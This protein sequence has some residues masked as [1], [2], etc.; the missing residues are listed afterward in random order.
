MIDNLSLPELVAQMFV[1][2]ASGYLFDHQIRYRAWEPTADKL[3]YYLENLGVGGV[4]LVGGSAA[5]LAVRS[6]QLQS[7]AKFPLLLAADIEE[8]VGQR[9]AGATWFGPPMAIAEIARHDAGKA[10]RYAE[11]MGAVTAIEA[12][13]IGLNWILAPVV[14]VNN[15]PDNPVINVRAFGETS[16]I[17]GKLASA[18]IRGALEHP[19]LTTAKHF[20]GHGDTAVDSHL[21]LPVLP[22]SPDRLAE[23]ELPP[24]VGAIAAGVDA[25]MS[26]HLL[27]P[28][29]D[30]QFPATLS[31]KILIGKLREEL[32]F[33][34]L[35]VT[36]ALV[37]GAIANKYGANEAAVLA[38]EAGA[39]VLL[40]PLDPEGAI[41][42]V[43][44]AVTQGR[45][46]IAQIKESV[47]R[48]WKAKIKVGLS[49]DQ[50]ATNPK[51][52]PPQP[53]LSKGGSSSDLILLATAEARATAAD[54]LRDSLKFGGA[55]PLVAKKPSE[56]QILRNLIVVDDVLG[57][58]FLGK[59]T[60]AIA[61]PEQF[62]YELQLIDDRTGDLSHNSSAEHFSPTL[63]QIFIRGNC[64]RGSA[65]LTQAAQDWFKNLLKTGELQAVVVYGSPYVLEQFLP[66]LPPTI[67][68]IFCFGQMPA[69]QSLTL[70]LL[71]G[72]NKT[73]NA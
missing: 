19:I 13:A 43:C 52:D 20:P 73:G 3:R 45:L 12:R 36:D 10:D 49:I 5:E 68:Y 40:M 63:L 14:D 48:I 17:V 16:E 38:A 71:F 30:D 8:G 55:L 32:G 59:H 46:D 29:W 9:F 67:P 41:L 57:C 4:I 60:P 65:G 23:I 25:V 56:K 61:I 1:V 34:G 47:N 33:D 31:R 66:H 6:H 11:Q 27:I 42:A 18:F 72:I 62:G 26:A 21:E 58:E 28:A 69:A 7:W 24:F 70:E 39:D 15:N 2:R 51:F 50:T 53:P 64:F 54:I 22:H 44:E 35:I 37:M